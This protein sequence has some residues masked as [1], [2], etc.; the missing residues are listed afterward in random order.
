MRWN[1]DYWN[2]R[3]LEPARR[4]A[5]RRVRWDMVA[6]WVAAIFGPWLVLAWLFWWL[7]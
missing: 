7:S 6:V 1:D 3:H 5:R 4:P 2:A